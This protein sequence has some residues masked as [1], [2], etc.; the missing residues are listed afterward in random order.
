MPFRWT[1]QQ[2][3]THPPM[4]FNTMQLADPLGELSGGANLETDQS[5]HHWCFGQIAAAAGREGEQCSSCGHP[6]TNGVQAAVLRQGL[7]LRG[8]AV[9]PV[10]QTSLLRSGQSKAGAH[11]KD[12]QRAPFGFRLL[13]HLPGDQSLIDLIQACM[14]CNPADER[15]GRQQRR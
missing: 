14:D 15:N 4:G 5:Q 13:L 7:Q 10:R 11:L 3:Q 9:L 1:G 12:L 2:L 8:P 6:S